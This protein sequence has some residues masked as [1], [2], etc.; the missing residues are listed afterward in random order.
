M[1]QNPLLT[2]RQALAY[3]S[4]LLVIIL[5]GLLGWYIFTHGALRVTTTSGSADISVA[6]IN[7][8]VTPA[9]KKTGNS[10]FTLLKNGRY[11]VTVKDGDKQIRTTLEVTPFKV[12]EISLT[13]PEIKFSQA[14]TNLSATSFAVSSSLVS[15]LDST[16]NELVS[17]DAQNTYAHT[18]SNITSYETAVWEKAGE[19]YAVG[20]DTATNDRKLVHI[21]GTAVE[22]A[23]T[24]AP[25]TKDTYL[26]FNYSTNG[27]FYLLQDGQLYAK[28][29]GGS[30]EPL[31]STNKEALIL[32]AT[33]QYV[34]FLYRSGEE[35]C[36][37]QFMNLTDKKITK[38]PIECVQSPSY[39]Y[40]AVWSPNGEAL[41]VTTGK[42]LDILD[43][44]LQ[45]KVTIPDYRAAHPVWLSNDTLAYTSGNNVWTFNT[46]DGTTAVIASTPDYVTVQS[47]RKADDTDI[48]YFTGSADNALTLYRIEP[49]GNSLDTA[50]KLSESNMQT[51]SSVCRIRYVNFT[52]L[53]LVLMTATSTKSQCESDT[54]DYLSSINTSVPSFQYDI[55]E[56][57]GASDYVNEPTE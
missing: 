1:N 57:L 11:I 20:R 31:G 27:D 3:A 14:V 38:Q 30:F 39:T 56:D 53:E 21:A 46:A 35:T 16:N 44:T 37:L 34:T 52:K 40:D 15:L 26:A 9:A 19:G 12:K 23:T 41:A 47:L 49:K 6:P 24:P 5:V 17:I 45:K 32:S 54:N 33:N 51:L 36:E 8:E 48:L 50:Q 2:P 18:N 55:R 28:K 43:K 42:S 4:A 25:I 22:P 7:D 10:M 29:A 13:P